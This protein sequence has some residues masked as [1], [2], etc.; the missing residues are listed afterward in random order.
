MK[1]PKTLSPEVVKLFYPLLSAEYEAFY[2]YQNAANYCKGV[3]YF[4]AGKYFADE[5]ADEL[6][7]AQKLQNFLVDWNIHP[8]L[9]EID[10]PKETTSLIQIIEAA[11]AMEYKLYEAYESVSVDVLKLGDV[12]VFDLFQFFRDVQ[13]KSVAEYSDKLNML[14]G[15]K[16]SKFELLM[17]EEKLF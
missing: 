17:L 1:K 10:E 5:S 13:T 3:G 11:Y 12:C 15:V 9:P 16:D 4:K 2:F 14:E 8:E 7:H 6:S